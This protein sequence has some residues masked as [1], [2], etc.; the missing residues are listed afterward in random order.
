[1]YIDNHTCTRCFVKTLCVSQGT[2]QNCSYKWKRRLAR[3]FGQISA[4]CVITTT[5]GQSSFCF[6]ARIFS[7]KIRCCG[8]FYTQSQP[9]YV[10][11]DG[12]TI[13]TWR[14]LIHKCWVGHKHPQVDV[15]GRRHAALQ[16]VLSKLHRVYIVDLQDQTVEGTFR[17]VP[18]FSW[19]VAA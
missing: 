9:R 5:R 12:R 8:L 14:Y 7:H 6:N 16:L 19:R 17:H 15:D 11:S 10:S 18:L 3:W 13:S 4:M 1:M 2:L